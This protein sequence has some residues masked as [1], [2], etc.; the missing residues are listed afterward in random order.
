M[1]ALETHQLASAAYS[2][3]QLLLCVYILHRAAK[4][5]TAED[6]Y[7][8][9]VDVEYYLR[10]Y[11]SIF[12]IL[13][14]FYTGEDKQT[15]KLKS[16]DDVT[17]SNASETK[18]LRLEDDAV[19]NDGE[20]N[21][22]DLAAEQTGEELAKRNECNSFQQW[23]KKMDANMLGDLNRFLTDQSGCTF[24]LLRSHLKVA[25]RTDDLTLDTLLSLH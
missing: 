2:A 17:S 24:A 22:I 15:K 25:L 11:E 5:S 19:G 6:A 9:S 16:E 8:K 23:T 3:C 1:Q 7:Q 13:R 4:C 12:T 21:A 18:R 20:V 10:C 14:E